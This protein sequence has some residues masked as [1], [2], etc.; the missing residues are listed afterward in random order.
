MGAAAV[1]ATVVI[2]SFTNILIKVSPQP[3]LAFALYRLW[4]GSAGLLAV[5]ALA[6]RRLTR[7][8]V[9]ASVPG[10]VLLGVE[11]AFFFSAIKHTSIADV[12]IIAALQPALVLLV[13]GRLFGERVTRREIAW[14]VVSLGGVAL[15]T[16]GSA[17]TPVWSLEGDLLA[18]GSLFMWTS[19][20]LASKHARS[21]VPALE[22]M[23]V[24][25]ITASIVMTPLALVSGQPLGGLQLN[26]VVWLVLFVAGVSGG[27][28]LLAWAH[29]QVDVSASSLLMLAH[30]VVAALAA[31]VVLGEPLTPLA[32]AGGAVVVGSLAAIVRRAATIGEDVAPPEPQ[33]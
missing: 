25:T 6:R 2:W 20:F 23:T 22:Y 7:R 28:V 29:P 30:P 8:A 5:L 14:T 1:L 24:V 12:A 26:D 21:T 10:G 4:L 15:V 33:I 18:V 32:I 17:G 11:I 19:Y 13:A 27:H 9:R 3:A 16:L 31:L